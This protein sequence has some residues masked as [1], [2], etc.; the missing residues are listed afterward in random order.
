MEMT[1][2]TK[3]IINGLV[4]GTMVFSMASMVFAEENTEKAKSE[5]RTRAGFEQMQE[6]SESIW[7]QIVEKGIITQEQGDKIMEK[8]KSNR[9]GFG[10]REDQGQPMMK[11][12]MKAKLEEKIASGELTQEQIDKMQ[13]KMANR[14]AFN[15]GGRQPMTEEEKQE[16]LEERKAKLAEKV[17]SGEL[18]QEQADKMLEGPGKRNGGRGLENMLSC[19]VEEGILTQEQVT[20]I[21]EFFKAAE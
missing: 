13:E 20:Q 18:T 19:L 14:P 3:N 9:V 10:F 1:K 12:Q 16:K 7:K 11:V 2:K 6:K 4:I 5:G 21:G 17:A 8:M 15:K